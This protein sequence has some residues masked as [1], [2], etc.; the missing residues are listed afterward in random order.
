M[1]EN[2]MDDEEIMVIVNA[3]KTKAHIRKFLG[4][5]DTGIY[6]VSIK[7]VKHD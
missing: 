4:L 1:D 3:E 6:T 7:V 2:M 5:Q